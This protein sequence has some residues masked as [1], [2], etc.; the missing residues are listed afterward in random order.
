MDIL[1]TAAERTLGRCPTLEPHR[2]D[3]PSSAPVRK[4]DGA[5]KDETDRH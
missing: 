1:Q 3:P 4:T 5:E 2:G